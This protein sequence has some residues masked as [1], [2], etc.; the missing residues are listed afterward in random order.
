MKYDFDKVV[1]RRNTSSMKWDQAGKVFGTE[2]ILPM[3]VADMDF[4]V[5]PAVVEALTKAAVHGVFGYTA[6]LPSLY[7]AFIAWVRKR[8]GWEVKREWMLF[9]PGGVPAINLAVMAFSEPGDKVIV[10]SPVYYPFLLAIRNNGRELAN[11]QL[12][13]RDGRYEMDFEDLERKAASGAKVLILCN[14]HNP[15]GRVWRRDEL[16]RLGEI[17]V[18]HEVVVVSDEIHADLIFKGFTHVCTASISEE[19]AESTVALMA[20][21]K[22]FNLAGLE[23]CA[24]VA[25]NRRLFDKFYHCLEKTGLGMTNTFGITAF[26]AAYRHG[27][28]WLRQLMEYLQEN[29]EFLMHYFRE[30]IPKI[31]VIRPEGTYLVWLDCRELGM[32]PKSLKSF[33]IEEAKVGLNDG[34]KF[35]AGGEGFQRIN[36]ACPRCTLEEGLRRIERAVNGLQ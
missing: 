27:E 35:G 5:P 30:R 12:R 15:V 13:F 24:V 6:R 18:T 14:P 11:N 10:Q 7:E 3:W 33:M 20:P 17:C 21:S 8:H 4:E 32:D 26:E 2:D 19:I 36:I 28:E 25:P 23:A 16:S 29:L 31:K 34:P 1:D 22:T 9:S